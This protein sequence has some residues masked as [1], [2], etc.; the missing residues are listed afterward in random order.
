MIEKHLNRSY[1]KNK[2]IEDIIAN[3]HD[4]FSKLE[5]VRTLDLD[6]RQI[7]NKHTT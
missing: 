4:Q 3:V 2:K 5:G 1:M 6:A 7:G